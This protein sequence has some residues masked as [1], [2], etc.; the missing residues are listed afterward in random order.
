MQVLHAAHPVHKDTDLNNF[1]WAPNNVKLLKEKLDAANE[2]G[3]ELP[4]K[5]LWEDVTKTAIAGAKGGDVYYRDY[6]K[7][8]TDV[9]G[10]EKA[11]GYNWIIKPKVFRSNNDLLVTQSIYKNPDGSPNFNFQRYQYFF[12]ADKKIITHYVGN[13]EVAMGRPHGNSTR[14]THDFIPSSSDVLTGLASE[15]RRR[16]PRDIYYSK[17]DVTEGGILSLIHNP[18]NLKQVHNVRNTATQKLCKDLYTNAQIV[19]REIGPNVIRKIDT[20]H[21]DACYMVV[22]DPD[23]QREFGAFANRRK[24]NETMVLQ[25]DTSFNAGGTGSQTLVS[26]LTVEYDDIV[27]PGKAP[28]EEVASTMILSTM[29]HQLKTSE[30]HREHLL[31]ANL[32]HKFELLKCR[33]VLVTDKEFENVPLWNGAEHVLCWNHIKTDIARHARKFH[34]R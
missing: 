13:H 29:V 25:Y 8:S 20:F 18:R 17:G 3:S 19:D 26:H 2:E 11:D 9:Y 4:R 27:T 30:T 22:I 28:G 10:R 5:Y 32:A 33:T 15:S 14:S 7:L 6:S 1:H 16:T 23:I 31:S 21:Q 24:P 12:V 34:F